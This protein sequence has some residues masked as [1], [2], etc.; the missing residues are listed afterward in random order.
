MILINKKNDKPTKK[1]NNYTMKRMGRDQ[2]HK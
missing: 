2:G 1:N